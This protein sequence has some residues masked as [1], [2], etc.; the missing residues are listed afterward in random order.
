MVK[1]ARKSGF[2][3]FP[4]REGKG[5]P[6]DTLPN[7]VRFDVDVDAEMVETGD[8]LALHRSPNDILSATFDDEFLQRDTQSTSDAR[9]SKSGQA[10]PHTCDITRAFE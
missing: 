2:L 6:H 1:S 7:D 4:S 9:P 10:W 3:A 5:H 8:E